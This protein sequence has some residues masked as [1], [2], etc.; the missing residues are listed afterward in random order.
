MMGSEMGS[1][2]GSSGSGGGSKLPIQVNR[3][4]DT[5]HDLMNPKGRHRPPLRFLPWLEAGGFKVGIVDRK[6]RL[7]PDW[8]N[9][10]D[11]NKKFMAETKRQ[12]ALLANTTAVRQLFV[13]Q[14]VKF[15]QL[16]YRKAYVWQFL[17]A[18]GEL[19][20]FYEA[21]EGVRELID[22]YEQLLVSCTEVE[23]Q[24]TDQ[25]FK[26]FGQTDLHA[27]A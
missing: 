15:L 4:K 13:R 6:P 23:H 8:K 27:T 25:Q 10:E 17:E 2:R 1:M 21:R 18:D 11:P 26:V 12:G 9:D 16:F 14:Y 24:K 20:A 22:S 3:V 19:D 7:P 5:L